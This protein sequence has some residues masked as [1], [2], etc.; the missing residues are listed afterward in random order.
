MLAKTCCHCT[1]KD[2]NWMGF[3][4]L[5]T[6]WHVSV[7]LVSHSAAQALSS[8]VHQC[9][10]GY[11][12]V[13]KRKWELRVVVEGEMKWNNNEPSC[14]VAADRNKKCL[15]EFF[16]WKYMWV[17]YASD[18]RDKRKQSEQKQWQVT[19]KV[20]RGKGRNVWKLW[21]TCRLYE[22]PELILMGRSFLSCHDGISSEVMSQK[23]RLCGSN[24]VRLVNFCKRQKSKGRAK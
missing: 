12:C 8:T 13:T 19:V 7:C 21:V 14:T 4:V 5:R 6:W 23:V 22:N 2:R 9:L 17:K 10:V 11:L 16:L 24:I 3:D 15:Y 1:H 20:L 18:P